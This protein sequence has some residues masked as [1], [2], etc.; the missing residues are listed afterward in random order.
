M[1]Y[2]PLHTVRICIRMYSKYFSTGRVG[3]HNQ[4]IAPNRGCVP[5]WHSLFQ[6]E[7]GEGSG[8]HPFEQCALQDLGIDG[9]V[10]R[11]G[12]SYWLHVSRLRRNSVGGGRRGSFMERERERETLMWTGS[13]TTN[14]QRRTHWRKGGGAWL[15]LGRL[16][17]GEELFP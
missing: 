15:C 3:D 6:R 2:P 12:K 7:G 5:H 13:E 16:M 8:A 9:D 11:G 1:I 14:G 4:V 17:Q 10:V